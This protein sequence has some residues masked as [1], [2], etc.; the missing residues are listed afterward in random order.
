MSFYKSI[1]P[2]YDHIFPLNY[3]QV[4]FVLDLVKDVENASILDVGCGTGS[5]TLALSKVCKSITGID[6]DDEMLA[7]AENKKFSENILFENC[8]M[9]AV[10][11]KF[12]RKAFNGIIC[13]GNTLVHLNNNEEIEGFVKN[14]KLLLSEGGKLLI[15]IINY[16]RILDEG[17]ASLPTI[18]NDYVKFERHYDYLPEYNE[19]IF[20]TELLI[21]QTCTIVES[22][23]Q[24]YPLRQQELTDILKR[25]GFN[26]NGE[27]GSFKK[28]ELKLNSI[29]F[30][31][32]AELVES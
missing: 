29:P 32:E 30:I 20:T 26:I 1:A 4:G 8:N 28:E 3:D 13:F 9:L 16:N 7:L 31:I 15:Q 22:K 11:D 5:L 2:F 10:S 25:N 21:K 17:I 24:L 14:C 18:E 6:V 27:Y 12:E 23:Q 19:I